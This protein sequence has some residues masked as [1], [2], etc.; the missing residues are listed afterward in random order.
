MVSSHDSPPRLLHACVRILID[1]ILPTGTTHLRAISD[2][3]MS[4]TDSAVRPAKSRD[5]ASQMVRPGTV[6]QAEWLR[7]CRA[8]RAWNVVVARSAAV[9]APWTGGFANGSAWTPL[10]LG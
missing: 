1:S 5:D 2:D 7:A 8:A 10:T 3:V 6:P 9:H 4:G